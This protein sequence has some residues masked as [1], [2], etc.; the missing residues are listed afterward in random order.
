MTEVLQTVDKIEQKVQNVAGLTDE[1]SGANR[2]LLENCMAGDLFELHIYGNNT[3]FG[4]LYPSKRLYP[5]KNL[6]PQK[7]T[8]LIEVTDENG[9]TATYELNVRTVLRQSGEYCDEFVIKDG[10]A[11]VIR[12]IIL[13]DDGS[14]TINEKGTIENERE[15]VIPLAEGDN[16]IKIL[17]YSANMYAKWVIKND[18][19]DVF[20]TKVE[21]NSEISQTAEE[22]KAE[23]SKEITT[24]TGEIEKEISSI[25]QTASQIQSKVTQN[26]NDITKMNSTITQQAGLIEAKLDSDDFTSSAVIG[27]INNRD[28]TSTAK[29]N[30]SN[31]NLT[32]YITATNLSTSGSTTIN[33]D[34][35][36]TGTI[37]ASRIDTSNLEIGG[38]SLNTIISAKPIS[39]LAGNVPSPSGDSRNPIAYFGLY[40]GEY[41]YNP[42]ASVGAEI[43]DNG[44]IYLRRV[45]T[46]SGTD[47]SGY[48]GFIKTVLANNPSASVNYI[49]GH[50]S[51]GSR[52]INVNTYAES[53][54]IYA[55][56]SDERLK[57]NMANAEINGMSIINMIK[58]FSF[59]WKETG[60]HQELGFS[61][62]Q[63]RTVCED[64]VNA[65]KQPASSEY[66]EILQVRN[67]NILP[68]VIKGLQ[69][70]YAELK[71]T[72]EEN[73]A[74]K[75]IIDDL[76]ARIEKLEK[77]V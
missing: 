17:N 14:V 55:E 10:K 46:E 7:V 6:Y 23:V 24:A 73:I 2:I 66:D 5:S 45:Y 77:G 49:I 52:G 63:L 41:I 56:T 58:L 70:A 62:Q 71:E 47:S 43:W 57:E 4:G 44:E 64:F 35:I 30:A 76:T 32:G 8:S 37:S 69:E 74:L 13:N 65:V 38:G 54:D 50:T 16:T 18:Y 27:L 68:Y 53:F 36:K 59:D 21:M 61:A 42:R 33:G 75:S 22:I 60:K 19:T 11:Y 1:T 9:N 31:I 29:I 40:N 34:N 15:F 51:A 3:V 20:A 28:G 26:T 25:S 48:M 12:R 72:K 39:F 67:F